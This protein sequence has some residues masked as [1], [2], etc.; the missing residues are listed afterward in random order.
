[1]TT[2]LSF[3]AHPDDD[4]LFMNPD[5][6]SDVQAGQPTW[7][8][9]LTAGNLDAGPGGMPYADQRIQGL[10]AAYA[11]A[12]Q[13]ESVWDYQEITLP[14]G[15]TL[16]SNYLRDAPHVH[17]VWTYIN[18]ANG[19][20]NGDLYRMWT[21][22]AFAAAPIEGRPSYTRAQFI[23][24]LKALITFVQ[25]NFLRVT[26]PSGQTIGDHIDHGYAGKFAATANLNSSSKIVRRMDAYF[27]YAAA[28]FPPNSGG[29]WESEKLAIWQAY[30]PHDPAFPA[31]SPAWDEMA[32]REFRRHVWMPGDTWLDL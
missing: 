29:Y 25:P 22:P 6:A 31:G 8:V 26:D 9:Y 17:L 1:V 7:V 24:M 14:S 18:A 11:R 4:L 32:P 16:A 21:D 10:R 15:R 20:D 13:V 28:S 5:I 23:A 19:P 2:T 12:A 27:G 3:V 30:K